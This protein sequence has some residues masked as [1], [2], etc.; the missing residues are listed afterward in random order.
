MEV[1]SALP[2]PTPAFAESMVLP[3][4]T[5]MTN[6]FATLLFHMRLL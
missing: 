5:I 2:I 1:L 6:D 3:G 4:I